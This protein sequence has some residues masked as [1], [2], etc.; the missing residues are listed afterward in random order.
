MLRGH[1]EGW[2]LTR[3]VR[4]GRYD[5]YLQFA[6]DFGAGGLITISVIELGDAYLTTITVSRIPG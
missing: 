2:S 3:G 1:R 6:K 4:M 5:Q